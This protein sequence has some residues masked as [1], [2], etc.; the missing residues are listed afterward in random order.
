M[1]CFLMELS[2]KGA[3]KMSITQDILKA[4]NLKPH[5]ASQLV[6][7]A[8]TFGGE[9]FI[10]GEGKG[11]ATIRMLVRRGLLEYC[12]GISKQGGYWFE[13]ARATAKGAAAGEAILKD[14]LEQGASGPDF[15]L[16]L[17]SKRQ[18]PED[19]FKH[20]KRLHLT[21]SPF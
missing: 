16:F 14:I 8:G 17:R 7:L 4:H 2:P 21:G 3:N 20:F 12:E 11:D 10:I 9:G 1:A 19:A 18:T 6:A 13:R 15:H 5:H